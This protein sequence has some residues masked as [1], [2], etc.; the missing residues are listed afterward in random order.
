MQTLKYR[1]ASLI[2]LVG[3]LFV[4]NG[5][6]DKCYAK[7]AVH[8]FYN[9]SLKKHFYTSDENEKQ[10]LINNLNSAQWRYEGIAWHILAAQQP[11]TVPVYRFFNIIQRTHFFTID[12]NEK[13]LMLNL[14]QQWRFEGIAWYAYSGQAAG[15]S[16]IYHFYSEILQTNLFTADAFEADFIMANYPPKMW[17]RMG[18]PA[19]YVFPAGPQPDSPPVNTISETLQIINGRLVSQIEG[20]TMEPPDNEIAS[21]LSFQDPESINAIE[22]KITINQTQFSGPGASAEAMIHGHWYQDKKNQLVT[23]SIGLRDN[24]AGSLEAFWMVNNGV[25]FFQTGR[26]PIVIRYK[27]EYTLKIEYNGVNGFTFFIGGY[28]RFVVGPGFGNV[29]LNPW[30]VLITRIVGHGK[31]IKGLILA[32]FDDVRVNNAIIFYDRFD[33][34][35]LDPAKWFYSDNQGDDNSSKDDRSSKKDDT[36]SKKDDT[37]SKKDDTSSKKDDTSSKK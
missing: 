15:T 2:L 22:T 32:L 3:F 26:L 36:S 18:G 23:A 33:V 4:V 7:S 5:L 12:E 6:I 1:A 21:H 10:H 16:L 13:A 27:V 24:G 9:Q 29:T 20:T 8:R 34:L 11:D 28:S 25:D 31:I 30:R 35:I 17:R 19:W 14:T 37:S